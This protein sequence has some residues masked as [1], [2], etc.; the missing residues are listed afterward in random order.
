MNTNHLLRLRCFFLVCP[1]M[2]NLHYM[3]RIFFLMLSLSALSVQAQNALPLSI[4]DFMQPASFRHLLPANDSS[5]A[6]KWFV[7]TNAGISAGM[8]FSNGGH[9]TIIA[10]PFTVQL[11]RR[12][13]NNW[14]AFASASLAPAYV[15]FSM[16]APALNKT[17][18][19]NGFMQGNK[20]NIYSSAQVGLMYVNDAK[21]FSISGSFGVEAGNRSAKPYYPVNTARPQPVLPKK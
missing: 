3:R 10:A 9:G 13:N 2:Y 11:N 18:T 7:T 8:F 4:M 12:L 19:Y 14:Y 6:K 17:G 5:S 16:N 20:L 15:N 1:T 21:T